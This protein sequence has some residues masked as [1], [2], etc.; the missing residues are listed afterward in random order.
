MH[1]SIIALCFISLKIRSASVGKSHGPRGYDIY[2]LNTLQGMCTTQATGEDKR[3]LWRLA[4][5]YSRRTDFYFIIKGMNT[6]HN[7]GN[8][9]I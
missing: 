7:N 1:R 9:N 4:R 8:E 6:D 3:K 5:R 2:K